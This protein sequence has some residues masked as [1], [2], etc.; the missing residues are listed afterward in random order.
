MSC[1]RMGYEVVREHDS[2]QPNI[3]TTMS[4][5]DDPVAPLDGERGFAAADAGSR[6]DAVRLANGPDPSTPDGGG[7]ETSCIV[8]MPLAPADTTCDGVDDDCSGEA[9]D[10]YVSTPTSCGVGACAAAGVLSCQEGSLVD[11]CAPGAPLESD[12]AA[13]GI[14]VDDDC[15]GTADEDEPCDTSP[16]TYTPGSYSIDLPLNCTQVTVR[17]WG[18][19][20]AGGETEGVLFQPGGRGGS[21]GYAESLL[22]GLSSEA[23]DLLVGAG[24]ASGCS[25]GGSSAVAGFSG[26]AGGTGVGADGE[27]GVQTGG[28]GGGTPTSASRGGSGYRGGG[29]G[30]A[31][32]PVIGLAGKGGGGGEASAFF[33][34]ASPMVIAG[35]GGGG[36]G[37][38]SMILGLLGVPGGHGGSGCGSAGTVV[39]ENGG[40]GGGGGA[41]RGTLTQVGAGPVP[42]DAASLPPNQAQGGQSSCFAG[43]GGYA[44]VTFGP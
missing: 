26:G 33:V 20:G 31:G 9:D 2:E 10:A 6:A 27:D 3:G 24:A 36:G 18:G 42:Y 32:T 16:R 41:C 35:G 17:L 40:G 25:A 1:M 21:G 23:L 13:S 22:T 38:A 7:M 37:A 39:N 15:D 5:T 11:S 30:G 28:G 29:G 34:A 43:G 19:A 8:E 44:I 14:G 4:A 12:T